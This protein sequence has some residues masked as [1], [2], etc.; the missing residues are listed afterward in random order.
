MKEIIKKSP[1]IFQTRNDNTADNKSNISLIK[2]G[3]IT[4]NQS[5]P[6]NLNDNAPEN[7]ANN[8]LNK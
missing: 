3:T 2:T 1:K 6:I 8:N 5:V 7:N 4:N